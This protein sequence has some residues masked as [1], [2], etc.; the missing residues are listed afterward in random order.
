M[1]RERDDEAPPSSLDSCRARKPAEELV[2]C[3]R[4]VAHAYP[5]RVVDRVR[6]GAPTPLMGLMTIRRLLRRLSLT[7]GELRG[8]ARDGLP[9]SFRCL[10][11]MAWRGLRC[12]P[13]SVPTRGP[14][15]IHPIARGQFGSAAALWSGVA[16]RR[17][18][19]QKRRGSGHGKSS[20]CH[21]PYLQHRANRPLAEKVPLTRSAVAAPADNQFGGEAKLRSRG[22]RGVAG[23]NEKSP[24]RRAFI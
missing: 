20:H 4:V 10:H 6:N 19:R 12:S 21:S 1:L 3:D 16:G 13:R 9:F 22:P 15:V 2:E 7:W 8:P 18:H 17:A 14:S 5:G 11:P 24:P 23:Q